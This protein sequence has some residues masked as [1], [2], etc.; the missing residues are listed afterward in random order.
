MVATSAS[1]CR[2][3]LSIAISILAAAI[4]ASRRSRIGTPRHVRQFL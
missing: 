1:S 4:G 3:R 2:A